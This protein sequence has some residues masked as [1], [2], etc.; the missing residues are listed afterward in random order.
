M[1]ITK[2]LTGAL[3]VLVLAL[4]PAA[5]ADEGKGK[6]KGDRKGGGKRGPGPNA[7]TEERVAALKKR[8]AANPGMEK[9]LLAKFDDDKSDDL[10]DAELTKAVEAFKKRHGDRRRGDGKGRPGGRKGDGKK[11]DGKKGDGKK[12]PKEGGDAS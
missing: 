11:G 2:L 1:K 12:K 4:T 10:S 9:R 8:I 5:M 6:G 3:T 7:T